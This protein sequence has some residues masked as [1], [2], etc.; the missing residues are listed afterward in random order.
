MFL[1]ALEIIYR[2]A[3][4]TTI[5]LLVSLTTNIILGILWLES[6]HTLQMKDLAISLLQKELFHQLK[7]SHIENSLF[8]EDR[9]K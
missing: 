1:S 2:S 7:L 9:H 6:F 4:F 8:K 5:L 3:N